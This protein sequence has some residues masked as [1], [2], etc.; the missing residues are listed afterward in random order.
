MVTLRRQSSEPAC[1]GLQHRGE[2]EFGETTL[3]FR[4]EEVRGYRWLTA[5]H[6]CGES[7]VIFDENFR[8]LTSKK[9]VGKDEQTGSTQNRSLLWL[10]QSEDYLGKLDTWFMKV[11]SYITYTHIQICFTYACMYI[12]L[13]Y[14]N[15]YLYIKYKLM[16]WE[17]KNRENKWR[18]FS[19]YSCSHACT[20]VCSYPCKCESGQ[21]E[22]KGKHYYLPRLLSTLFFLRSVTEPGAHLLR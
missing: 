6:L 11:T 5:L 19:V 14:I 21:V 7:W 13:I 12:L 1:T 16:H 22:V 8:G 18:H 10:L 15:T 3:I 4:Q 17:N 20:C 2:A 9:E